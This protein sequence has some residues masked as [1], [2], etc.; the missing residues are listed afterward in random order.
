MKKI[1]QK[2]L[3]CNAV[4]KCVNSKNIAGNRDEKTYQNWKETM[5]YSNRFYTQSEN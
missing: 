2:N 1:M 5:G 4:L 3:W